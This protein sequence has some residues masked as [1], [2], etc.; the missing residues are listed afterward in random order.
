MTNPQKLHQYL[1]DNNWRANFEDGFWRWKHPKLI[2][3]YRED[4]AYNI[5]KNLFNTKV[6]DP[7]PKNEISN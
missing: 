5:T 7:F 3:S 6:L 4:Q 2:L 1:K